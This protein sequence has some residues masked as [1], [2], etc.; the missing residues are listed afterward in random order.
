MGH[1]AGTLMLASNIKKW[2]VHDIADREHG[3]SCVHVLM[4]AM[5]LQF[6]MLEMLA[7]ALGSKGCL[8]KCHWRA[9][10]LADCFYT[11]TA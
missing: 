1:L 10:T 7:T 11:L 2:M 6:L 4:L 9:C 3:P 5:I 8:R